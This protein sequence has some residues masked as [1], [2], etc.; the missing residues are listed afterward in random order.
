[1][2]EVLLDNRDFFNEK[3][4]LCL[5]NQN[6]IIQGQQ[7]THRL[8]REIVTAVGGAAQPPAAMLA[9]T[10]ATLP[11]A[12]AQQIM[13]FTSY[14][15]WKSANKT[16]ACDQQFADWFYND[17]WAGYE[18]DKS[19]GTIE[20]RLKH[21]FKRHKM[22][23]ECLLR[24]CES[25]PPPRPLDPTLFVDWRKDL[26]ECGMSAIATIKATFSIASVTVTALDKHKKAIMLRPLPPGTPED[27]PF[28]QVAGG[29]R[30]DPPQQSESEQA[31][32]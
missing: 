31:H 28:R 21:A 20:N 17:L 9:A 29:K 15:I 24:F 2:P 16:K 5:A 26:R 27:S 23:V 32:V 25:H 3:M 12:P 11:A 4:T 6:T 1:M 7:E 13:L 14:M 10:Q 19:R 18:K 8:L 22:V 30:K